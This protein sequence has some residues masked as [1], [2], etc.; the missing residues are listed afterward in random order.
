MTTGSPIRTRRLVARLLI[1]AVLA[2]MLGQV[3]AMPSAT[4]SSTQELSDQHSSLTQTVLEQEKT[5]A[6]CHHHGNAQGPVCCFSGECPMLTLALP[7]TP[8][9]APHTTFL[10][11][12]YRHGAV[13]PPDGVSTAPVLP[14]PRFLV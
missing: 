5:G 11:L 12:A 6:P 4:L 13:L 14:P 8:S 10:P 1:L 2:M 7:V 9:A 3:V